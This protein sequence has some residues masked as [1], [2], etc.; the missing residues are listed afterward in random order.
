MF[1]CISFYSYCYC[2]FIYIKYMYICTLYMHISHIS[3][4]YIY[5]YRVHTH[6]YSTQITACSAF[7]RMACGING[8]LQ[9]ETRKSRVLIPTQPQAC[10]SSG[11]H[12]EMRIKGRIRYQRGETVKV[13]LPV[14]TATEASEWAKNTQARPHGQEGEEGQTPGRLQ[15]KSSPARKAGGAGESPRGHCQQGRERTTGSA[16]GCKFPSC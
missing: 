15:R 4:V 1:T 14:L 7:R 3:C 6:I 9:F 2:Y 11:L 16:R 8:S 10:W 13:R 12:G 5:I